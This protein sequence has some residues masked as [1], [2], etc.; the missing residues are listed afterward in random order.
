M[1]FLIHARKTAKN[2]R[3]R[4]WSTF[5]DSYCTEE[6]TEKQLRAW[7]R[8]DAIERALRE[9]EREFPDRLERATTYGTS[10]RMGLDRAIESDWNK[11]RS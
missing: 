2:V 11:E 3:Y 1:G 5:T 9:Y 10:T 6:M 8:R 7:T 4:I